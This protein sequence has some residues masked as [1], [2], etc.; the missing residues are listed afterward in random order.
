MAGRI[1]TS[2]LAVYSGSK[3]FIDFFS[4]SLYQ[5]YKSKGV[6]VISVTPGLVV[7]FIFLFSSFL[8]PK[9]QRFFFAKG[10]SNV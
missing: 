3:A 6:D 2:M 7:S 10:F 4:K 1:P 9:A 8:L 5:E